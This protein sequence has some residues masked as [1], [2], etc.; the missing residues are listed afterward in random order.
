MYLI[1]GEALDIGNGVAFSEGERVLMEVSR[2]FT[3]EHLRGLAYNSGFFF[4]VRYTLPPDKAADAT[5]SGCTLQRGHTRAL[6]IGAC[7]HMRPLQKGCRSAGNRLQAQ[8]RSRQY[9]I[10]MLC[11]PA[12]AFSL[13]WRDTD[14]LFA[15]MHDW[16]AAPIG[17]R[18]PFCFYYGHVASFSKIKLLK[19]SKLA[20]APCAC[21]APKFLLHCLMAKFANAIDGHPNMDHL[22]NAMHL[23]QC[24]LAHAHLVNFAIA[25]PE[26]RQ[27]DKLVASSRLLRSI[28]CAKFSALTSD[29]YCRANL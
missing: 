27:K 28:R 11:S 5:Q 23:P 7:P 17:L 24:T 19:V 1:V 3:T 10:Q 26:L 13:A 18:H 8:W 4:E 14:E 2:K 20:T 9:S 21:F 25:L 6:K 16:T 29:W 15:R 12:L 22:E